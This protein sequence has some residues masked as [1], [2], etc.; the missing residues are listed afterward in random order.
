MMILHFKNST[1]AVK[2]LA[3]GLAINAGYDLIFI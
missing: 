2:A 3:G 1:H